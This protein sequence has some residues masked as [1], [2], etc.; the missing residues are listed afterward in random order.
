MNAPDVPIITIDANG[1][2]LG[3]LASDIAVALQGKRLSGYRA[4]IDRKIRVTVSNAEKVVLT[5]RKEEQKVYTHH[6]GYPG[7]L[8]RTPVRR[9]LERDPKEVIRRAV[10]NMLPKTKSR[11]DRMKR[12][13]FS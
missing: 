10:W 7:G 4:H 13:R 6:T 2:P 3:R 12:L 8:R 11:S 9:V 1:R 5:G